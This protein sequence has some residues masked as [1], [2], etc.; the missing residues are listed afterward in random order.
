MT[1]DQ[2]DDYL[3]GHFMG[4]M[5]VAR[6]LGK[7]AKGEPLVYPPDMAPAVLDTLRM[8]GARLRNTPI[9]RAADSVAEVVPAPAPAADD[10]LLTHEDVA[11]IVGVSVT[12]LRKLYHRG[13]G[14]RGV[15]VSDTRVRFHRRD[16]EDWIASR[17]NTSL[18][19]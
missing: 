12:Q 18:G 17:R 1:I 10:R 14:P 6:L 19:E 9:E 15:A 7:M 5:Q 11:S 4:Q 2:N 8:V 3:H 13:D 16:V